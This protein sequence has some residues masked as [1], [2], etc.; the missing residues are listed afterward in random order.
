MLHRGEWWLGVNTVPLFN[1]SR[2]H[3]RH[4][5]STRYE[6]WLGI[7]FMLASYL[8]RSCVILS[9]TWIFVFSLCSGWA[10]V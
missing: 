4:F 3:G 2:R 10:K 9:C 7:S 6:V 8:L 1:H 5:K